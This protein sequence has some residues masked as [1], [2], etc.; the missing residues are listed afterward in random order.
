MKIGIHLGCSL[1]KISIEEQI[2][3]MKENGFT[4][5]FCMADNPNIDEWVEKAQAAGIDHEEYG[6]SVFESVSI[7]ERFTVAVLLFPL[8]SVPI[9]SNGSPRNEVPLLSAPALPSNRHTHPKPFVHNPQTVTLF[10]TYEL[11]TK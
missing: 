3:L 10:Q 5:A 2:R 6:Y 1:E 11:R 7:C 8:T 9:P 4:A